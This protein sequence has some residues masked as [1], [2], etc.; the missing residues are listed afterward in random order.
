M[1]VGNFVGEEAAAD[2]DGEGSET[3]RDDPGHC[4]DSLMTIKYEDCGSSVADPGC[5]IP[6]SGSEH[7]SILDPG[8]EH[9]SFWIWKKFI[10]DPDPRSRVQGV[11]K[12]RILDPDPQH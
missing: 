4:Y 10:P 11:I 7:F 8:S 3:G 6:D 12:H 2:G 1:T 9:F 5:F